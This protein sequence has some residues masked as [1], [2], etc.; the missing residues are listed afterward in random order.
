MFFIASNEFDHY[1]LKRFVGGPALPEPLLRVLAH[2]DCRFVLEFHVV[3]HAYP[4]VHIYS[5]FKLSNDNNDK[6]YI[7]MVPTVCKPQ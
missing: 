7:V 6:H 1:V 3:V 4:P 2:G 5:V